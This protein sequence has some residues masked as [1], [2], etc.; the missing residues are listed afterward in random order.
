VD[1]ALRDERLCQAV[2]EASI[3]LVEA[4]PKRRLTLSLI[5]QKVVDLKPKLRQL[6]RLPRTSQAVERALQYRPGPRPDSLF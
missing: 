3:A 1:W 5:C 2:R 4:A 6:D